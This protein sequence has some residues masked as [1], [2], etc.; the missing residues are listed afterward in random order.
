VH[1]YVVARAAA[2]DDRTRTTIRGRSVK[3]FERLE[4]EVRSYCRQFPC[5][6][7]KA[8]GSRMI[9]EDGRVN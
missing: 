8:S 5:V 6:F 1:D 7:T 4:S 3:T 2:R 9:A